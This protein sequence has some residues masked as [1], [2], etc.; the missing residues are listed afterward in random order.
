MTKIVKPYVDFYEKLLEVRLITPIWKYA[1]ELIEKQIGDDKDNELILFCIY[2][3]LIDSGN[4]CMSLVETILDLKWSSQ[5]DGAKK[6]LED[7]DIDQSIFDDIMKVSKEA[8]E[9]LLDL[10]N[11]E[12]VIGPD[13]MFIIE[14][15]YYLYLK[16]YNYARHGIID[17][18][19]RLFNIT[20]DK[21][22]KFKIEDCYKGSFKLADMQKKAVEMGL[23]KNLIITGGPGTG[24][25]TTILYILLNILS[26]YGL[27]YN[28]Y[29]TA[30]SGKAASRMK[31]S[32]LGGIN[33]IN[34]D[35]INNHKELLDKINGVLL[36]DENK[37][38]EFTIHRLLGFDQN[39]NKFK[40]NINNQFE[41]NSIFI[42]DEASMIDINIFNSLLNAIP[43][44]ARV[45][46]LGDK[47][48][49]P[50][51]EA[52]AVFG[53]LLKKL[54]KDN[55]TNNYDNVV[56]L[57]VSNRFVDGTSIDILAKTINKGSTLDT[58]GVF[59]GMF[60]DPKDF[61][62]SEL[63]DS[64]RNIL[65]ELKQKPKDEYEKGLKELYP[66]YYYKNDDPKNEK[67]NIE[68]ILK[69]WA[70]NFFIERDI[71]KLSS[72]LDKSNIT[73]DDLAKLFDFISRSKVITAE[74]DGP[75]GVNTI[76]KYIK[77]QIYTNK[78]LTKVIKD[79]SYGGH[80]A[81]ELMMITKNNKLLDLYNGDS[82]IL[83]TFKNDNTLYFV[84]NKITKLNLGN[85]KKED[86]IFK[87]DDYVFYPL[88]LITSDEIDLSYAIT[89]H[90]SQGSDYIN[91][92]VILPTVTGHPLLNRQIV[93]T[94][95][96][97]TKG[98]TYILSSLDMLNEAS[99]TV[100]KRDTNI[101]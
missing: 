23:N 73:L 20:G 31:E 89:V 21:Q 14:K 63:K 49:L 3:S 2:F 30:A 7:K 55:K 77:K 46:I 36:D 48:Q 24:K 38:E 34:D 101:K 91:I 97:R 33:D 87:I 57:N 59:D 78:V 98:V 61:V 37:I 68:G 44:G 43:T 32:L 8:Y 65:N 29:L 12:P 88:R 75:R 83:V 81:G 94:A 4:V 5:V 58:I 74:N 11:L 22:P 93:Y 28:I 96:T 76:N 56:E 67:S 40:Y 50:S 35:F 9:S 27:D 54:D 99:K 25:T 19:D 16:K 18:I 51:V 42:I 52:G 47:N 92:L 39:T 62:I 6:L 69:K 41:K 10:A 15:D 26:S 71:I 66:I 45:F 82:G 53:D 60:K 17:S 95:I 90:K 85:D 100:L 13:K 1:L 86:E 84:V 64:P 79:K 72:N 80:Y 70:N